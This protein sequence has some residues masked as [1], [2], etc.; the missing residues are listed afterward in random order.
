M[1]DVDMEE[2]KLQYLNRS[3]KAR[4]EKEQAALDKEYADVLRI[5]RGD[6]PAK[7]P[8]LPPS[9]EPTA[10]TIENLIAAFGPAEVAKTAASFLTDEE[11]E[12]L[13]PSAPAAPAAAP[14]KI[15]ELSFEIVLRELPNLTGEELNEVLD[16]LGPLIDA[17]GKQPET[18]AAPPAP[19]ELAPG[20]PADWR[21]LQWKAKVKLANA[22]GGQ[23]A[24]AAE[25]DA[26]L[27]TK[28]AELKGA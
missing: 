14:D 9:G 13:F 22:L 5:L 12:E 23:V 3:A 21:G 6:Q 25:A 7:R 4:N 10:L 28:E 15:D 24:N 20:F 16:A 8:A 18:P 2:R 27:A 19:A 1:T 11:R 17:G 26:F